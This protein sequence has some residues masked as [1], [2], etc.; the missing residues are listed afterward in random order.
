M[1]H[2]VLLDIN[3]PGIGGI[4]ACQRIRNIMPHVGIIMVTVRDSEQ[5]MVQRLR[6]QCRRLH[7]KAR[8]IRGTGSRLRA[9]IR[10]T[11]EQNVAP[12]VIRA[13]DLEID[14]EKRSLH[15]AG[16]IVHLTPTEF[17]L[18]ALLMRH[19]GRPLTHTKLLRTIWG[20]DYGDEVEYSAIVRENPA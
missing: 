10:R 20:A 18:L 19:E 17:D 7:H 3:L 4:E 12:T 15:R 11:A 9:V 6:S 8:A 13:R 5:D 1:F 2:H 14:L 16:T